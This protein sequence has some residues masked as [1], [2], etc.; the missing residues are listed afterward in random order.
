MSAR[1]YIPTNSVGGFHVLCALKSICRPFF[2][3]FL[4]LFFLCLFMAI[5]MVYGS[6]QARG[7]IGAAAAGHSHGRIQTASSTYT[8]THSNA[9]SLTHWARPGI[10]PLSSWILVWFITAKPRWEFLFFLHFGEAYFSWSFVTQQVRGLFG[11]VF[12]DS[13]GVP[14]VAQR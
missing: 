7:W 6:S 4:S 9:G 2:L 14:L 5:P 12:K 10:E 8:T 13:W 11:K 1:V 3:L